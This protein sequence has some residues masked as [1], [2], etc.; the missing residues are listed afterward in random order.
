MSL[1]VD[2]FAS[3]LCITF[4]DSS[5]TTTISLSGYEANPFSR[6]AALSL[7]YFWLGL[8]AV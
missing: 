5:E 1:G 3:F 4:L 7:S 8:G 6:F 2:S